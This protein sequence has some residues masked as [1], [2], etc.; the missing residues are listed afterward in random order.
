MGLYSIDVCQP[1]CSYNMPMVRTVSLSRQ[2]MWFLTTRWSWIVNSTGARFDLSSAR[3]GSELSKG[4]VVLLAALPCVLSLGA[5][6][7]PDNCEIRCSNRDLPRLTDSIAVSVSSEQR[8]V[9]GRRETRS[10]EAVGRVG[11]G[12]LP[13]GYRRR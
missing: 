7:R 9:R 3:A 1:C 12:H 10:R 5:D 13:L 4:P 8:S 2:M 11:T 6:L